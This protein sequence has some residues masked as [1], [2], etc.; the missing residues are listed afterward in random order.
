VALNRGWSYREQVGAKADG[1]TILDYLASTRTHSTAAEWNDRLDRGEVE[2]Q[3]ACAQPSTI[4]RR[5]HIVVWHR[6][7]W[8]EP[9]VPTE[10]TIIHEDEAL[11][12]VDKPSGLPTM[13][14]GGFLQ[15][16][17]MSLLREQYPEASPL[18]R[19]GRYTSGLVLFARTHDAA[20]VLS[21]AWR[22][23]EVKKTYRA[24]GSGATHTDMFVI[25][26]PIGPVAHPLLGEVEAAS[27][28][29]KPSHTVA[30]VLERGVDQTLFSVEIK[31]GRPHQIRI[32]LAYA[33]HPLVGDPLYGDGG[34]IKPHPGLPGDGGYLLHSERLVFAHPLSGA[35]TTLVAAPPPTLLT[36]DELAVELRLKAD[37][38][39]SAPAR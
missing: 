10:F 9:E 24:L 25:N 20:A 11:I 37:A 2:V 35:A 13:P 31:T 26:A 7:P 28:D 12:A 5:G 18:H 17:L 1:L 3:G 32:H 34:V 6:P 23:H 22:D 15:H 33:G 8:N 38:T 29:G 30:M 19:L 14:A 16:T 39:A 36:R 4:L 27:E 21:K